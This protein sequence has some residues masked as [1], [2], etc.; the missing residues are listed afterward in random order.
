M[1]VTDNSTN[2]TAAHLKTILSLHL[3]LNYE[4]Q[5]LKVEENRF[6]LTLETAM[7]ADYAFAILEDGGMI[8][9]AGSSIV[10]YPTDEYGEGYLNTRFS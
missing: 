9:I 1:F 2:F 4:F 10:H 6:L 7:L 8:T 5:F 3:N